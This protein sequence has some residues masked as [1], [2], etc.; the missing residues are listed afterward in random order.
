MLC[1]I[2]GLKSNVI[3]I[4]VTIII[5]LYG[6]TVWIDRCIQTDRN[7]HFEQAGLAKSLIDTI[8]DTGNPS[9]KSFW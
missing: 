4:P 5:S 2:S 8:I 1:Y 7:S 6:T 3:S 9:L